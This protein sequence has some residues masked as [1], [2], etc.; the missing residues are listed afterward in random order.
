MG[1]SINKAGNIQETMAKI[2]MHSELYAVISVCTHMPFVYC[3]PNSYDDEIFLYFDKNDAKKG[4]KRLLEE[5]NPIQI[6]QI[7]VPS[8]L[9]FFT[10]LFS[11]GVNAICV[12]F[13]L[14]SEISFQ[15]DQLIRRQSPDQM[16]KDQIR[17][18]NPE[19]HLTAL[20]F[21]QEFKKNAEYKDVL[22]EELRELNEEMIAHFRR[23]TYIVAVDEGNKLPILQKGGVPYQPLFTDIWEFQKF[24]PKKKFGAMVVP[25]GDIKD[26]LSKETQGV[27][28][29]PF[30][31]DIIL[32]IT[33]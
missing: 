4:T 22:S 2:R 31:A 23:G 1:E 28:I 9:A 24:N 21:A 5:K 27:V 20:Y 16:P 29:N 12:N 6:V 15:L 7:D 32:K 3:D 13:G 8:R 19:L 25:F 33:N 26:K 14:E 10:S 18:E 30:G 17:V 11:M